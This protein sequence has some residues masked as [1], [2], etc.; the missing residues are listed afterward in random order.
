MLTHPTN[1]TEPIE[2]EGLLGDELMSIIDTLSLDDL[3]LLVSYVTGQ[4]RQPAK[5]PENYIGTAFHQEHGVINAHAINQSSD[6]CSEV[7]VYFTKHGQELFRCK[8]DGALFGM[9]EVCSKALYDGGYPDYFV[10][11]DNP[12]ADP[13]YLLE[14]G[15]PLRDRRPA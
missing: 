2:A 15:L 8:M 3:R 12:N 13:R 11:T 14:Q 7:E 1:A 9:A 6:D 4:P 10:R 5:K